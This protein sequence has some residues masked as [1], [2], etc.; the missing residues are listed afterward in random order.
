LCGKGY[1]VN[2]IMRNL[3]VIIGVAL[4]VLV[5]TG[6]IYASPET[7]RDMPNLDSPCYKSDNI[8]AV[9][10]YGGQCTAFVYGRAKEK[11]KIDIP[12]RAGAGQ[13]W[14]ECP[15]YGVRGQIPRADSIAVWVHGNSGHV[16]YVERVEGNK[17]FINEAN[18]E[19][20]KGTQWGGGYDGKSKELTTDQMKSHVGT[21]VG[22]IYLSGGVL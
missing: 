6:E 9:G 15:K 8:F 11:L 1:V 19:T 18:V 4:L 14:T 21:L 10:G 20:F 22:Y 7:A 12:F 2:K 13:W 16:A 3:V 5:N 17:V